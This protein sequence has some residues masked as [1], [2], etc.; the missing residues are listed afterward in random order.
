MVKV[1]SL[2]ELQVPLVMVQRNTA[3]P[4]AGT[5]VT[6]ELYKVVSAMVAVPDIFVHAPT[7][8]VGELAESVKLPLAH[9][10]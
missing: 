1:T 2:V 8:D 7:P 4:L 6:L 9:C 10:L 5:P 3:V